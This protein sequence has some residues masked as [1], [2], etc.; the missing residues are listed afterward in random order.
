M[1]TSIPDPQQGPGGP[2]RR[3][4]LVQ[5][6]LGPWRFSAPLVPILGFVFVLPLLVSLGFWQ[7]DRAAQRIALMDSVEAAREQAPLSVD[8][9]AL[10]DANNRYLPIEVNGRL[11]AA[12]QF[13]LDN[14]VSGKVAGY[15]VLIPLI[16]KPGKAVLVNRGWLPV[17][18][19]RTQKPDVSLPA[20]AED[21][22]VLSGLAVV[23]PARFTLGEALQS[24][25]NWPRLLQFE[26]FENIA[27]ALDLE[28]LPR[29]LQPGELEWG[30]QAHWKPLEK[31]PEKN[32][33]YALQWFA[34]AATLFI[35]TLVV[36]TRRRPEST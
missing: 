6:E 28:L 16:Y 17:G 30:F 33:A 11:D 25:D 3:P 19:S 4:N 29:V 22:L 36:C 26:D 2:E 12:R 15:E 35:I 23:P 18:Q 14:R 31:G 7:L 10:L 34:L 27:V 13:L 1:T 21:S 24:G 20:G 5:F 32:Y 8:D 9:A